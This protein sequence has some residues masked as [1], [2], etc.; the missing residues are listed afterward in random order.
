ML[1]GAHVSMLQPVICDAVLVDHDTPYVNET[2]LYTLTSSNTQVARVTDDV[3]LTTHA[4][5]TA[6]IT[7]T[8]KLNGETVQQ[9]LTVVSQKIY[10]LPDSLVQIEEE[11]FS[12]SPVE[13]VRLSDHCQSIGARA[14]ANCASLARIEIPESVTSIAG[15]AFDGCSQLTIVCVQ[16]S[17]GHI[18]AA[19][20]AIPYVF[21]DAST[22]AE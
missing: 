13:I 2:A 19:A 4:A 16:G 15:D 18:Y 10:V 22:A 5:G 8:N 12:G 20:H 11:A 17:A 6:V 14:F 7:A 1:T 21:E 3:K 9:T